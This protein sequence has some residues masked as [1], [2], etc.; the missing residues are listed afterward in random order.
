MPC[1]A[2]FLSSVLPLGIQQ[3]SSFEQR[4]CGM[5]LM[6]LSPRTQPTDRPS[7]WHEYAMEGGSLL[8][9]LGEEMGKTKG[10]IETWCAMKKGI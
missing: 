7:G 4:P 2:Y 10:E 9:W 3:Q 1:A 8:S 6:R 5:G